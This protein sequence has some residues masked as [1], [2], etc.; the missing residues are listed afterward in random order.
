MKSLSHAVR[1]YIVI[2]KTW[3]LVACS[4]RLYLLYE[5]DWGEADLYYRRSGSRKSKPAADAH[6]HHIFDHGSARAA[7]VDHSSLCW[8]LCT[9]YAPI[10]RIEHAIQRLGCSRTCCSRRNRI[11]VIW[12][13]GAAFAVLHALYEPTVLFFLQFGLLLSYLLRTRTELF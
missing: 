5:P 1:L 12:I 6:Y 2:C 9:I 8:F 10:D 3:L 11:V 7:T 4:L 13:Y